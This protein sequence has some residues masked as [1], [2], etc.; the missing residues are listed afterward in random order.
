MSFPIVESLKQS[1]MTDEVV[2]DFKSLIME[3]I[4]TIYENNHKSIKDVEARL[5]YFTKEVILY[6]ELCEKEIEA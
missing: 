3:D 5:S 6:L 1:R 2:D 4:K